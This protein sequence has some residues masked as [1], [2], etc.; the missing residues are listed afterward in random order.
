M[1]NK[2]TTEYFETHQLYKEKFD[3]VYLP[4]KNDKPV[5]HIGFNINDPFL[6]RWAQKSLLFWKQIRT[7]LLIFMFL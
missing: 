3:F 6:N 2:F 4:V 5:M 7:L 1:A